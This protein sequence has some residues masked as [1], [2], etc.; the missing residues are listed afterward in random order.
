MNNTEK[1]DRFL[2]AIYAD[3]ETE[4]QRL[5]TV[6]NQQRETAMTQAEHD[7]LQT[8]YEYVHAEVERIRRENGARV[9]REVLTARRGLSAKQQELTEAL[10]QKVGDK[11]LAFTAR[12]EYED[13]LAALWQDAKTA[14]GEGD[15]TVYLRREDLPLGGKLFP[16]VTLEAGDFKLGGF[17]AVSE[18]RR[19]D[20]SYDTALAEAERQFA[21]EV[22]P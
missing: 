2:A 20:A 16:G 19:V 12:R 7:A 8:S 14:L 6:I 3:G 10:F 13:A 15:V 22:H 11:I 5:L 17:I 21:E 1:L 9:S 4:R 18:N